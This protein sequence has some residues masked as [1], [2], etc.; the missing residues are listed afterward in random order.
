MKFLKNLITLINEFGHIFTFLFP[1]FYGLN[2]DFWLMGNK[3]LTNYWLPT[4][5]PVRYVVSQ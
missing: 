4:L 5:L 3:S 1:T 2:E